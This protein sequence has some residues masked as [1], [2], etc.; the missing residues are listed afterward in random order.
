ML[1]LCSVC[2]VWEEILN[3]LLVKNIKSILKLFIHVYDWNYQ[4]FYAQQLPLK[5]WTHGDNIFLDITELI[6][7][8]AQLFEVL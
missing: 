1:S 4:A 3:H 7:L 5:E 6:V 2:K 8:S